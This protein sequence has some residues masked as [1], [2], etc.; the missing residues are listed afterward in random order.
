[1]KIKLWEHV[2]LDDDAPYPLRNFYE[3]LQN[4]EEGKWIL[5]NFD[6]Y[7]L[8]SQSWV[9]QALYQKYYCVYIEIEPCPLL[10]EYFIRFKND[11]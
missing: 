2:E 5:V 3:W 7:K 11:H 6:Q 4:S 1:M 9:D 10:T 8:H